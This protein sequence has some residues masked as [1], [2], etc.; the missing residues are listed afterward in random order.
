MLHKLTFYDQRKVQSFN[1]S[2]KFSENQ[3]TFVQLE[4]FTFIISFIIDLFILIEMPLQ[5]KKIKQIKFDNKN[6]TI[7]AQNAINL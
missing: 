5:R 1:K 7:E 3:R 4:T 2:S 6:Q